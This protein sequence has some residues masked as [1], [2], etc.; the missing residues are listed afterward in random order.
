MLEYGNNEELLLNLAH[1]LHQIQHGCFQI[2]TSLRESHIAYTI[3]S[4]L[5]A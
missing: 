5:M 1:D 3:D 4:A 2:D